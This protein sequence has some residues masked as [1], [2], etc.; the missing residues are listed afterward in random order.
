MTHKEKAAEKDSGFCTLTKP[1]ASLQGY[2]L[3]F[4]LKCVALIIFLLMFEKLRKDRWCQCW[5]SRLSFLSNFAERWMLH[6]RFSHF[7]AMWNPDMIASSHGSLPNEFVLANRPND[8]NKFS[9]I[10]HSSALRR[11]VMCKAS[12]IVKMLLTQARPKS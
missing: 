2:A 6:S 4:V 3:A 9:L 12:L 10:I 7:N 1:L 11:I 5:W 8:T